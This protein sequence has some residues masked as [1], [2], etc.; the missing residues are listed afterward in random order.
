MDI[1][2]TRQLAGL[3]A[4]PAEDQFYD[5]LMEVVE[6]S[7][8]LSMDDLLA[9]MEHCRKAMV[10]VNKLQGADRKKWLSAVFVNLNK[11]RAALQREIKK[12]DAQLSQSPAPQSQP[13]APVSQSDT[14]MPAQGP[15]VSP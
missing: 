14:A 6:L 15:D 11:V 13:Q 1:S 8:D 5:K 10:L 4:K 7:D 12:A 2:R 9:R 3:P